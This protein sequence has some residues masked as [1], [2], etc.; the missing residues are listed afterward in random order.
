MTMQAA[1]YRVCLFDGAN[2]IQ[3]IPHEL[4]F[5][6]SPDWK[7]G[8]VPVEQ[9]KARREF[10]HCVNVLKIALAGEVNDLDVFFAKTYLA[11]QGAFTPGGF[12]PEALNTLEYI[13]NEVVR[14][15]GPGSREKY[16]RNFGFTAA[17]FFVLILAITITLKSVISDEKLATSIFAVG[18]LLAASMFGLF[19]ATLSRHVTPTFDNLITPATDLGRTWPKL[20][21]FG[22]AIL[23]VGTMLEEG[24]ITISVGGNNLSTAAIRTNPIVACIFG[25]LL[26]VAERLVPE[27]V[28]LYAA[29][30]IGKSSPK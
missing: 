10:E 27:Q 16:L 9:E 30:A 1:A 19:F 3:K 24:W 8:A 28:M 26:G 4:Y 6:V 25:I 7:V 2:G 17:G 21:F 29:E 23:V 20:V 12:V 11:A 13:K 5:Y 14:L 18:L 15:V 22:I